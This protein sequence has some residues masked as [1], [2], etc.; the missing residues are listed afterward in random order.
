MHM[1]T[2]TYAQQLAEIPLPLA[3]QGLSKLLPQ[4]INQK[5]C[6]GIT[7]TL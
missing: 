2:P 3:G 7:Q 5:F 1:N 4:K 6:F